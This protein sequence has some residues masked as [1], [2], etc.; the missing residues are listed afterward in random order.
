[1]TSRGIIHQSSCAY[2]PQQNSV[3]ERK[4]RH[5]IETAR[6]MLIHH[7][8]PL[9]FWGDAVLTAGYLINRMP[10]SVLQHQSVMP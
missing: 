9:H 8:V 7:N 3:A 6:T 1:M 2:T 5:L 10:S 4:N